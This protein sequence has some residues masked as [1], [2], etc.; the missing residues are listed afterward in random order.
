[1]LTLEELSSALQMSMNTE[2]GSHAAKRLFIWLGSQHLPSYSYVYFILDT[3]MIKMLA[4][5]DW[6]RQI[7]AFFMFW[8]GLCPCI[9]LESFS[10][11]FEDNPKQHAQSPVGLI[12]VSLQLSLKWLVF[13]K[14]CWWSDLSGWGGRE[15]LTFCAIKANPFNKSLKGVSF[16]RE[17]VH[18]VTVMFLISRTYYSCLRSPRG[19]IGL[20]WA[21]RHNLKVLSVCNLLERLPHGLIQYGRSIQGTCLSPS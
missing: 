16:I 1:M 20:W 2:R 5:Q 17:I 19:V 9:F 8:L 13:R 4:W 15:G 7:K 11:C 10:F 21:V 18:S 12:E 6:R 14:R 3:E